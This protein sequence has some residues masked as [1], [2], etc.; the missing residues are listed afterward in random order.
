MHNPTVDAPN[1]IPPRMATNPAPN[2]L[3]ADIP[4]LSTLPAP[5]TASD[6]EPRHA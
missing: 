4:P 6:E 5:Q 1:P 3:L 2:A